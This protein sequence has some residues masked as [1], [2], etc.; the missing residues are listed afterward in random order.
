[1]AA[2][3]VN[4]DVAAGYIAAAIGA[5]K[6]IFLTDVDG[7]YENYPDPDSLIAEMSLG[8][9]EAMV[10]GDKLASGMIP[11]LASCVRALDSG[12]SAAHII[13]G[14]V[15]HALLLEMLTDSGHGNHGGRPRFRPV[16]E[17]LA[18]EQ[19]RRQTH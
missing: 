5:H 17:R 4:A 2:T 14:T 8:E 6:I 7:L 10:R 3:T 9:A 1:M 12:V 19:I 11:K 16:P 15:P 18:G 13:N